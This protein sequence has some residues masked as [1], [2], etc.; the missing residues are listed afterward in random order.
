MSPKEY[1]ELSDAIFLGKRRNRV[2]NQTEFEVIKP[3]KGIDRKVKLIRVFVS[4]L[5]TTASSP[6]MI[7]PVG[8]EDL[9]LVSAVY[10]DEGLLRVPWFVGELPSC[11][12]SPTPESIVAYLETKK[13]SKISYIMAALLALFLATVLLYKKRLPS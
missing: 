11:M 3:L 9:L 8:S 2:D 4:N 5:R 13:G 12:R 10:N 1:T 7:M 6:S